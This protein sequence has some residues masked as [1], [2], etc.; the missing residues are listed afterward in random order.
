MITKIFKQFSELFLIIISTEDS[1]LTEAR[2]K[3]EIY[4]KPWN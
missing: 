1:I 3:Y 2:T 4:E